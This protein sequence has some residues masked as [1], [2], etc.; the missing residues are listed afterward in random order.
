MARPPSA[1]AHQKVLDAALQLIAERGIDG[2]SMDAIAQLSGVSKATVYKHWQDKE[3]L[4]ID[5]VST[6]REHPPEFDSGNLRQDL[7]D[8]LQY[9]FRFERPERLMK[10]WPRII[11]HAAANPN[12]ALA[13]Q[14]HAFQPRRAQ[15]AR[16]LARG[17]NRGELPPE[18]DPNF[19]M[20]FLIGPIMHRRFAGNPSTPD[21][22]E[23]VVDLFLRGIRVTD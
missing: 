10:I 19:A 1:E 13:L 22:P 5:V 12:F 11:G 7:I 15:V 23:Q 18:V 4:C 16:M 2:T 8:Y 20:D 3:A 17:A 6:L 21:F 14:E 9:L